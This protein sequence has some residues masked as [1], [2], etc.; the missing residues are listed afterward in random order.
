MAQCR[1]FEIFEHA[2]LFPPE[3]PV[4]PSPPRLDHHVD[5][6]IEVPRG[7]FVKR[8]AHGA[9]EFLSPL[10]CPFNYGSVP[11]L[12]AADGD[13][14]D[15]VVLGPRLPAGQRLQVPV[16]GLIRFIDDGQQ[17]DKLICAYRPLTTTDRRVVAG[18]F[19]IYAL[20]KRLMHFARGRHR[21][22]Q[23]LGWAESAAPPAPPGER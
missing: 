13:A 22:T 8:D 5:V 9:I 12:P 4:S 1:N 15:A 17:D 10:P 23:C 19:K 20:C 16:R 18:F 11:C 14:Q 2:T 21:R 3:R 7:S 6:R